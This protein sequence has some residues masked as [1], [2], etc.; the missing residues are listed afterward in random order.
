MP[1]IPENKTKTMFSA[2]KLK[3]KFNQQN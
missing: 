3:R 2:F 1:F